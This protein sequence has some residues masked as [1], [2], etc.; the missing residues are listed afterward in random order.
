MELNRPQ[1]GNEI[2]RKKNKVRGLTLS[3]I[4]LYYKFIV[5][6]TVWHWHKRTDQ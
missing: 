3:D 5:I 4:K 2:L 1:M 6:K